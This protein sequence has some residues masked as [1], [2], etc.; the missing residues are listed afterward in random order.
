MLRYVLVR[1]YEIVLHDGCVW[2]A[3]TGCYVNSIDMYKFWYKPIIIIVVVI[4]S[5]VA[6]SPSLVSSFHNFC[7]FEFRRASIKYVTLEGRGSEKFVTE[8]VTL[9]K[10]ISYI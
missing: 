4:V 8:Q 5:M 6:S 2:F 7:I 9:L 3:T 1:L 10:T